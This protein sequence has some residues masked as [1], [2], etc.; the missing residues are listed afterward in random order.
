MTY[1]MEELVQETTEKEIMTMKY[2]KFLTED[3]TDKY[4][5]FDFSEYLP[6]DDEPGVW[7]PEVEGELAMCASGYHACTTDNLLE[8]LEYQLWEVEYKESP[9]EYNDKVSGKQIR[10]VRRIE[11]WN[12]RTARL[13]A[14]WCAR[15]ALKLI[16]E[17]DPAEKYANGNATQE[18]LDAAW[19]AVSV[20]IDCCMFAQKQKL[21]EML[22]L[23]P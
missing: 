8:W 5:D 13:F 17:P 14:V 2:Y 16:D 21:L 4:S 23:I 7:L 9:E 6:T 3:N 12:E 20:Y 11:N 18:D 1:P 15:E 22:E 10:F 19:A